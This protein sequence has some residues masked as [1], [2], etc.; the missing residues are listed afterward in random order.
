MDFQFKKNTDILPLIGDHFSVEKIDRKIY[1]FDDLRQGLPNW[2]WTSSKDQITF[3]NNLDQESIAKWN[4]KLIQGSLLYTSPEHA[5]SVI[6]KSKDL[7]TDVVE[8]VK[9]DDLYLYTGEIEHVNKLILQRRVSPFWFANVGYPAEIK[10]P[11]RWLKIL[12][13]LIKLAVKKAK[14]LHGSKISDPMYWIINGSDPTDTNQG[15]PLYSS[16]PAVRLAAAKLFNF[17]L[18]FDVDQIRSSLTRIADDLEIDDMGPFP[19]AVGKRSGAKIRPQ[20]EFYLYMDSLVADFET[21]KLRADGRVINM[22][23]SFGNNLAEAI[24]GPIKAGMMT[25]KQYKHSKEN[26]E[27]TRSWFK[28][29]AFES[30]MSKYDNSISLSL[31]LAV[32][33]YA[34]EA[35]QKPEYYDLMQI[36]ELERNV[37]HPTPFGAGVCNVINRRTG[38]LSGDK[39]TSMMGSLI[40]F[41]T[42]MYTYE[43]LNK[44]KITFDADGAIDESS[45]PSVRIQSDDILNPGKFTE[46]EELIYIQT[47]AS[48][49]LTVKTVTGRRFLMKHVYPEKEYAVFARILQQTLSNEHDVVHWGQF[50]IGF[51]SRISYTVHPLLESALMKWH[52]EILSQTKLSEIENATFSFTNMNDMVKFYTYHPSV[53]KFLTSAAGEQWYIDLINNAE[54]VPSAYNTLQ[55][56]K[57]VNITVNID[58]AVKYR[59]QLIAN[60]FSTNE[61]ERS[62]VIK[63]INHGLIAG[64]IAI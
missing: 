19:V 23:S 6:N 28:K 2:K 1:K 36:F 26:L 39:W 49:G 14:K 13:G 40:S 38:L 29:G 55:F 57:D 42:L 25:L 44:V 61:K 21:S 64:N 7:A 16:Q 17:S 48:L 63:T 41:A 4:K 24:V 15:W 10:P 27:I 8:T 20:P 5:L 22:A 46:K 33:Y 9:K 60:L 58:D 3:K 59:K 54:F 50:C 35:L 43:I 47:F 30:D 11:A 31:R 37:L 52:N 51:A 53:Q 62:S 56:L 34:A 12:Q 32:W 18:P 45:L